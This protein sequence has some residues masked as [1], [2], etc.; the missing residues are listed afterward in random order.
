MVKA[1]AA[2]RAEIA[3]RTAVVAVATA[4]MAA[5]GLWTRVAAWMVWAEAPTAAPPARTS[6]WGL[7]VGRLDRQ[8]LML[9]ALAETVGDP[10]GSKPHTSPST[11]SSPHMEVTGATGETMQLAVERVEAS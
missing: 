7:R 10:F 2:V 3:A 6:T 11:A 4:V 1:Q 5:L 8:T 9:V